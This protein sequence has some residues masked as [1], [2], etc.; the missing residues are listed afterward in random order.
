MTHPQSIQYAPPEPSPS[1]P[2]V[3]S[4]LN[5]LLRWA[6]L[7]VAVQAILLFVEVAAW[8]A[9]RADEPP[10][11]DPNYLLLALNPWVWVGAIMT[12]WPM[13]VRLAT[14]LLFQGALYGSIIGAGRAYRSPRRAA[15]VILLLHV[16]A[17]TTCALMT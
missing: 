10:S 3:E 16:L 4:L 11:D 9:F 7:G 1:R 6:V 12:K 2:T 17:F 5:D 14:A 8:L 15:V 13:W